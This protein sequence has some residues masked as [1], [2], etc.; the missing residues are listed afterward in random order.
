MSRW[1]DSVVAP[2][3]VVVTAVVV[4]GIMTGRVVGAVAVTRADRVRAAS[5]TVVVAVVMTVVVVTAV[6]VTGIMTRRVVRTMAGVGGQVV[7]SDDGDGDGGARAGGEDGRD[8]D[9]G[10]PLGE[11]HGGPFGTSGRDLP[12]TFPML[13]GRIALR[14]GR[15]GADNMPFRASGHLR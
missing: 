1:R 11:H 12:C 14:N 9:G 6:V 7:R 3:A 5:R 13:V 15:T 2:V 8:E 10:D 4:A